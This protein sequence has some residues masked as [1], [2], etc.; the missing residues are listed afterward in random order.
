MSDS[1]SYLPLDCSLHDRIEDIATR[2]RI[3]RRFPYRDPSTAG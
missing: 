1:E 2:R 3:V